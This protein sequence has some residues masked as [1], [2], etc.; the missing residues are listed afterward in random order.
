M[1][2][3]WSNK[4][5]ICI[6]E[7]IKI[8]N[9]MTLFD[10]FVSD[11]MPE[12]SDISSLPIT[13]WMNNEQILPTVWNKTVIHPGSEIDIYREPKGTDPF[14]ITFALIFGAK[15]ILS[16]LMPKMPSLSNNGRAQGKDLDEAASKGNRVKIN[17]VIPELAGFNLRYPDVMGAP[18]RYFAGPREQWVEM[19]LCVGKGKYQFD[20][21]TIRT[22]L[23]P[24]LSLGPDAHVAVYGPG[25]NISAEAAHYMWYPASEVSATSS[26]ASGLELTASSSITFAATASAF[27][28][29]G[30]VL[31]IA[32]GAGS[33]PSDW[34]NGLT[35]VV[36]DPYTYTVTN[37]TGVGGRDIISGGNLANLGFVAG[38]LIEIQGANADLYEVFSVTGTELQLNYSGGAPAIG[39]TAGTQEMAIG[40]RGLRYQIVSYGA[41]ALLLDRI[42][43]NGTIDSGWPGWINHSSV[44]GR[45][46]LDN[47]NL[48]GSY[49]GPFPAN[50]DNEKITAIEYDV[51]FP[52]GLIAFGSKGQSIVLGVTFTLE[53]RDSE[54]AGAWTVV[55]RSVSAAQLNAIGYTYRINLP[56]AMKAE[57]RMKRSPSSWYDP[58]K[59]ADTVMWY[60]LR[61]LAE[62]SKTSYDDCTVMAVYI[63]G[64]DRIASQVESLVNLEC[65][66]I[67][68]VLDGN[69]QWGPE[70]PTRKISSW[71]GHITRSVG[72][73][74]IDINM[75]ELQRLEDIWTA[76][77]D[78]Y[79]KVVSSASTVKDNLI[80]CLAAGFA[81]L[82]LD[83]GQIRPVRDEPRGP[84]FNHMY[85]PQVMRE[86]LSRDFIASKPDDFDGVDVEYLDGETWN[87]LTV[88]CRIKDFPGLPDDA[89]TR[90][91]K[92]KLEGVHN[93]D[94]AYQHGM[95]IRLR[96]I[97]QKTEY[98][99][100]TEYAALNSSYGDY[101]ALGDNVSG[102]AKSSVL[103][104]FTEVGSVYMLVSS[105]AF[106]WSAGGVHMVAIRRLDGTVSGPYV[107]TR[108]DDY[109][110]TISKSEFDADPTG[111][112]P[113]FNAP[114]EPPFLQF[115]PE[116]I[117]CYP[118]IITE[119]NPSGTK[120]CTVKA[121]NYAPEIYTYDNALADN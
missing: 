34:S 29:V 38:D 53:Y 110:L 20:Y 87:P 56:Y 116:D 36:A 112:Y 22:G 27:T 44:S 81:E 10:W 33:F 68:P 47:S 19:L 119:V 62:S 66:R 51:F 16:A 102:Y 31:S 115:G 59:K 71:I 32:T 74:E 18:R 97:F 15:A 120:Y 8:E 117:W 69:G 83:K 5:A 106:D 26:G 91:F 121:V 73:N 35:V 52:G 54:I 109:R 105:E 101:V 77:G 82:T 95:R 72:Y 49:R 88:R 98:S 1:I 114:S 94:K 63:R 89:G 11:G 37:G 3:I 90:V 50:A 78:T 111:F 60:G 85:N 7:C 104:S 99:F 118:A 45:A 14:S 6:P 30:K 21:A 86:P 48:T 42:K 107:A 65:T 64:G 13:V 12:E 28:Y 43:S 80:E 2:R 41:Q 25:E 67:L 24:F 113:D 4:L 76:R 58:T 70:L 100:S 55:T 93:R 39:L 84:A 61:G 46:Q 103:K 92:V 23:T 57:V 9:G 96:Q 17:D 40:F 79:D 108:L 75:A